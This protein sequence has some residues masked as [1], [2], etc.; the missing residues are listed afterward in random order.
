MYVC[1]CN[2]LTD[3]DFTAAAQAGATT[4]SQAFKS[5]G[6]KPQC[7][8]CVSCAREVMA[9]ARLDMAQR[10]MPMAAE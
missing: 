5:L 3:R 4:V 10:D 2:G 7:G 6:E 8:R 9:D 1:I